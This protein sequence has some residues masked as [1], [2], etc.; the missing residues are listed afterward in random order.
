M[1]PRIAV[2]TIGVDD[3]ENSLRFYRDGLGWKTEGI[4]DPLAPPGRSAIT[5]DF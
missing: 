4:I 5:Q 2:I 1:K 3:L